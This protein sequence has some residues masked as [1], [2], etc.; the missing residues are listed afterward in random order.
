LTEY[1]C[2]PFNLL[3]HEIRQFLPGELSGSVLPI[4]EQHT[5]SFE[6]QLL[7]KEPQDIGVLLELRIYLTGTL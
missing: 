7:S 4:Q 3:T 6:C 1:S 5:C 2:F